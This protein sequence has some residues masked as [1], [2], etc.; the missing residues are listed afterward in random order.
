MSISP[1]L[2]HAD[3]P[4][5]DVQGHWL[6]ARLGKRVLRPGGAGLTRRLLDAASVPEADVVELAPGLGR[7]AAWIVKE[8]PRSYTGVDRD[9][10]AARLVDK[11]VARHG[12]VRVGDAATTGLA[13]ACA[14]VVVGEAMLTMQSDRGKRAIVAEAVRVL[15]PGG[16]YAIHELAITPDDIS[17]KV[18]D[19]IRR[20]LAQSIRV[21]ARPMTAA[22]WRTL[23]TDAGLV[24]DW[25]G[26]APMALLQFRRN[27]ADE[28][29]VGTLRI[30]GN[31]VRDR[32]ARRRVLGM[33]ATFIRHRDVLTGIALVAH[34]PDK[35]ND[36]QR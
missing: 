5:E 14:D 21:N 23:L 18:S 24:V 11:V 26:T 34:R 2:P 27:L 7:T 28:G 9:P 16:R 12:S 30:I 19:Q 4:T 36:E 35:E 6:L 20:E 33:R 8:G 31:I 15:R 10:D 25:T 29:I 3:R 32:E 17:T 1:P 13:D 22:Q